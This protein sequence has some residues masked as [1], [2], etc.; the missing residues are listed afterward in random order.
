MRRMFQ[1]QIKKPVPL[2]FACLPFIQKVKNTIMLLFMNQS[3][4]FSGVIK[5][6]SVSL[7]VFA[8]LLVQSCNN[9]EK[10]TPV[11]AD[12]TVASKDSA[13]TIA[14]AAPPSN[15]KHQMARVNNVNI[16]FVIGGEG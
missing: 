13:A 2:T 4:L 8:M 1:H 3:K 6:F 7:F 5:P 9:A 11:A 12:T 10:T 15:F 14:P 16:H